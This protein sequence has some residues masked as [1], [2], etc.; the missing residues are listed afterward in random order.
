MRLRH[1]FVLLAALGTGAGAC[2]YSPNPESGQLACSSDGLCP[3][4]YMCA[5]DN[6]CWKNGQAPDK[7]VSHWVFDSTGKL[8]Q[9]C[10]SGPS[11]APV[12]LAGDYVDVTAGTSSALIASYYCPWNMKISSGDSTKAT[13]VP[14]QSCQATSGTMT[15]TL[16]G[17]A[18]DFTTADGHS[19]VMAASFSGQ[20]TTG[21]PLTCTFKVTGNLTAM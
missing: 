21:A 11:I 7:F 4:G 13:I 6:K 17:D 5:F 16:H 18:F 12:P 8:E 20:Y 14:G 2:G 19:A 1:L 9:S 3:Q 10:S 15:I